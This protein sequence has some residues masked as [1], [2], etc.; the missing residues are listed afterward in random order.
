MT[1]GFCTSLHTK[2]TLLYILDIDFAAQGRD[3]GILQAAK[4]LNAGIIAKVNI[5]V[6]NYVNAM[7]DYLQNLSRNLTMLISRV[8]TYTCIGKADLTVYFVVAK[9]NSM[10]F[11]EKLC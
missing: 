10:L 8:N 7:Q 4:S 6:R 9:C 2:Q 3:A 5:F 1:L 11:Y